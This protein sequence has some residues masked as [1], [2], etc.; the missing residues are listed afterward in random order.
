MLESVAGVPAAI[1]KG[2][3]KEEIKKQTVKDSL[4]LLGVLSGLPIGPVGKP[5][6]YTMDVQTGKANPTGPIDFARGIVTG[7]PGKN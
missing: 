2:V 3:E 4:M 6:G 1:Y 5:A 7:Q